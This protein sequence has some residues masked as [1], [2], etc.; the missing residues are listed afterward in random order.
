MVS[1]SLVEA[2]VDV[3][4]P[5][6]WREDGAGQLLQAAGLR[7]PRGKRNAEQSIVHVFEMEGGIPRGIMQ[8]REAAIKTMEKCPEI[9]TRQ[10]IQAYFKR[11]LMERGDDMLDQKK[12]LNLERAACLSDGKRIPPD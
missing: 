1:T 5:T 7:N 8:Q 4:F 6:V 10:A 9:N 3:D 12:I 11:L 2:G